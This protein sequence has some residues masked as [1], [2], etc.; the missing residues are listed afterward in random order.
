MAEFSVTAADAMIRVWRLA[1]LANVGSGLDF[2]SINILHPKHG[3]VGGDSHPAQALTDAERVQKI[4]TT[5][6]PHIRAAFEAYHLGIIR[7]QSARSWPHKARALT[8]GI[9]AT[10]YFRR[11]ESGRIIVCHGLDGPDQND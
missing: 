6:P 9:P 2:P 8:L 1:R 4:V 10:T 3:V 7:E 5:M 11:V